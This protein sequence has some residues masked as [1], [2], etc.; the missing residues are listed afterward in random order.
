MN[1]SLAKRIVIKI[2]SALLIDEHGK[3]RSSW[4]ESV[5]EDIHA[6]REKGASVI[7]VSSGGIA[8]GKDFLFT[9][10][11]PLKINE[12]QAAAACGQLAL[13]NGYQEAFNNH[14]IHA[15]QIL[16]TLED[17]DNRRRYLNARHTLN[18][19][20]K[21]GIVP[22]INEND[23]I[24]TSEIRF[25]DNDRLAA[26]IAQ[27][28]DADALILLS[29]VDGLYTANPHTDADAKHIPTVESITNDI[30]D[31]AD[32]VSSDV[33]SGGMQTKITAAKIAASGGCHTI[34]AL[35][36]EEHPLRALQNDAKHTI[37]LADKNPQSARDQW[38]LH[39]LAPAGDIIIDDGASRAL[40]NGNSLLPAGVTAISGAFNRGD[41]VCVK[42]QAGVELARGLV[43]YSAE[44]AH[45]ILGKQT[46]EI[47]SI[48]HYDGRPELIHRSDLVMIADT[49]QEQ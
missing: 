3:L 46:D 10:D 37:F 43:A 24:A 45:Q 42:N 7:I 49:Q 6:L 16:L 8:L 1:I 14:N 33:G 22:I 40:T 12:K 23:T 32:G 39:S 28:V 44:E 36:E 15:A 26:R 18:T 20:L 31:M 29:D 4:V 21:S 11:R 41:A 13:I 27:M 19:L 5:C 30:E 34:I 17:S 9:E 47:E 35:G 48:L 38:I 2:G 25:G